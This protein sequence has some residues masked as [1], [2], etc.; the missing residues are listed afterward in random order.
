[1]EEMR[2]TYKIL[3]GKS[4]WMSS[5]GKFTPIFE[6]IIK[7]DYREIMWEGVDCIIWLRIGTSGGLL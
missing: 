6:G 7:V 1:M 2:N 3:V 5:L 4:E